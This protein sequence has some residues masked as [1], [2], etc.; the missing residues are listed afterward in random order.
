MHLCCYDISGALLQGHCYLC[1]IDFLPSPCNNLLQMA[2]ID[3]SDGDSLLM[4][5]LMATAV[6]LYTC[7]VVPTVKLLQCSMHLFMVWRN[8]DYHQEFTVIMGEEIHMWLGICFG[9][10]DYIKPV[11]SQGVLHIIKD[12]WL[13][14]EFL[15]LLS[16]SMWSPST[17]KP[18]IFVCTGMCI[19]QGSISLSGNLYKAGINHGIRTEHNH[20]PRQLFSSGVRFG[21][22]GFRW[23]NVVDD[24]DPP[25]NN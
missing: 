4:P 13:C 14:H 5:G 21:S 8:M 6:R 3:W 9:I 10:E 12:F 15:L 19:C 18:C 23:Y 25:I 20:S 16:W 1:V 7:N 24:G 17:N 22:T 2:I 11:S